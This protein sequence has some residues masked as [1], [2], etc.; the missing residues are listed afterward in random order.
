[1]E[2]QFY[3]R[4][5]LSW[6]HYQNLSWDLTK[7]NPESAPT[8]ASKSKRSEAAH[9]QLWFNSPPYRHCPSALSSA[10]LSHSLTSCQTHRAARYGAHIFNPGIQEAQAGASLWVLGQPGPHSETKTKS[11]YFQ[12][13]L[14]NFTFTPETMTPSADLTMFLKK[15]SSFSFLFFP[16]TLNWKRKKKKKRENWS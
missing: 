6:R 9:P 2:K 13:A 4:S 15:S 16:R 8:F 5:C 1:M 12:L 3:P 11:M 14:L 10:Q 7:S